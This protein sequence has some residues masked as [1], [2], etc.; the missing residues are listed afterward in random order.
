MSEEGSDLSTHVHVRFDFSPPPSAVYRLVV[1]EGP[2]RGKDLLLD[3]SEASSALVGTG[4]ACALKLTDRSVSRRHAALQIQGMKLRISDL[5]SKNGIFVDGVGVYDGWLRGGE[6]IRLGGTTLSIA[7]EDQDTVVSLPTETAFGPL[8]GSS[9]E[10]RR[11]YPLLHRLAGSDVP[12]IIEGDTGTGKEVLAEAL[13]ALGPRA[14]QPFVVFD[15]TT[16]PPNLLESELFGHERGAFTG[17]SERRTGLME[18]AHQGTLFIDEIGDLD[19]E[20]Q[21]KL[22]RAIER[23][24]FRRVG[25]NR[26]TRVDVRILAATRRDLDREVSEGRFRDDLFHRLSVGRVELPPLRRRR[27][28]VTFLA[29]HFGQQL[30]HAS[31]IPRDLLLRWESMHWSGNVRELRNAV[32]RYIALGELGESAETR[33]SA[34]GSPFDQILALDIPLSESRRRVL[35][36]FEQRYVERVL[37]R[38][39]GNVSRAARAAG[40]GRRYLHKLI[41]KDRDEG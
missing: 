18:L 35:D 3:G 23:S 14:A 33:S 17:A 24:E 22:L 30:G 19:R 37:L 8:L 5:D 26:V 6:T 40:V 12:V 13:H 10:M 34:Q 25:S 38:F 36:E 27:G 39:S 11:L 9:T 28:D 1:V 21:P 20:L 16:V 41:A 7:C 32:A 4:P 2:D 31:A 15:C 29:I